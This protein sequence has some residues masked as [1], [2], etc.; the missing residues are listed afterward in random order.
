MKSC[1]FNS[2]RNVLKNTSHSKCCTALL[3]NNC[4]V[5]E[6]LPGFAITIAYFVMSYLPH[7]VALAPLHNNAKMSYFLII[8]AHFC[9][10]VVSFCNTSPSLQ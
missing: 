2:D 5:L 6:Y 3:C 10:K 7:F 9:N 8:L 1:D 4:S